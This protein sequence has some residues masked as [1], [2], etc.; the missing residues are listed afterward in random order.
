VIVC[1]KCSKEN[2][3]TSV[4]LAAAMSFRARSAEAVHRPDAPH[5]CPPSS[6]PRPR[7]ARRRPA[8]RRPPRG[9]GG[10]GSAPKPRAGGGGAGRSDRVPARGRRRKPRLAAVRSPEPPANRFCPSLRLQPRR[11][12]CRGAPRRPPRWRRGRA[13]RRRSAHRAA[14]DGS[15]AGVS[16]L[17]MRPSPPSVA[18]PARSSPG[19]ATC[20][21][22]RDLRPARE[23]GHRADAGSLN[24]VYIKLRPNEPNRLEYDD[25]FRIGRRSSV[26]ALLPLGPPPTACA[27]RSPAKGYIGRSRW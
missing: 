23:R 27:V 3:T 10:G 19:T 15:E 11:R 17:P 4:R 18:T 9:P 5:G 21:P 1:D 22:T 26:R 2:R 12:R 8:R 13:R 24:G 7:V 14:R 16:D 25:V 20:R 6:R